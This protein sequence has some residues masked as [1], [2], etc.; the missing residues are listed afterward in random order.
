MVRL[1]LIEGNKD[2]DAPSQPTQPI[3]A[4]NEAGTVVRANF[5]ARTALTRVGKDP[6]GRH[7]GSLLADALSPNSHDNVVLTM[8]DRHGGPIEVRIVLSNDAT[9][10]PPEPVPQTPSHTA[11]DVKLIDFIAHELRNPM[12]TVLGLSRVL[13]NRLELLSTSDQISA[14]Q[15]IHDEAERA[16][17]ILNGILKL[18]EGRASRAPMAKRVP[19]HTVLNR[20]VTSHRRQN[21]HRKLL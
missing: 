14:I 1:R 20:I 6:E 7:I 8:H 11:T 18:A 21:P 5:R 3:L 16:L 19:L 4:I 17:L 15:S 10:A 9:A 2:K 13:E 12:G